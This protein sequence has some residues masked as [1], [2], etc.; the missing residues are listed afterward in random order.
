MPHFNWGTAQLPGV[1]GNAD[2]ANSIGEALLKPNSGRAAHWF[3]RSLRD[4]W[5]RGDERCSV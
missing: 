3:R 4:L 2:D 5:S 1:V